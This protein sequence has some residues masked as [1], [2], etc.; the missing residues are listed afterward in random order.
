MALN[1][2]ASS[3]KNALGYLNTLNYLRLWVKMKFFLEDK[4]FDELFL[5][6]LFRK[7][8]KNGLEYENCFSIDHEIKNGV[9]FSQE[10]S[11]FASSYYLYKKLIANL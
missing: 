10:C 8:M 3:Y 1:E 2:L 6:Y 5:D 7:Q 11:Q 4:V 9:Y